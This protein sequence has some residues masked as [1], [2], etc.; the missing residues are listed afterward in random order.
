MRWWLPSAMLSMD[1]IE[2]DIRSMAEAGFSGAEVVPMP[3]FDTSGD[4]TIEWGD[5]EV[6]NFRRTYSADC[7]KI[8]FYH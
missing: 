6:E 5:S 8:Q 2:K 1:G 7:G 4:F 3:R